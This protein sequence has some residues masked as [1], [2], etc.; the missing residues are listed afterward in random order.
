MTAI[1]PEGPVHVWYLTST[2][3]RITHVFIFSYKLWKST[4]GASIYL[5]QEI[6]SL[7]KNSAETCI[8]LL[9]QVIEL[10]IECSL[11]VEVFR[12]QEE[13][14]VDIDHTILIGYIR[15]AESLGRYIR[16]VFGKAFGIGGWRVRWTQSEAE[17]EI[18]VIV[19]YRNARF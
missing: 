16:G 4:F 6:L 17:S 12:T 8:R 11:A 14:K 13:A 19:E 18:K 15:V 2:S 10:V 9:T 5:L 7:V 3:L 1:I